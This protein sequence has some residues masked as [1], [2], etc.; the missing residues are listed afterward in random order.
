MYD[1]NALNQYAAIA[2][3]GAAAFVPQFDAD[4]NQTLI[5]T[6]TGIWSAIYNAENR[7]TSFTNEESGTVVECTYDSMGRR[8]YKKVTT[9]GSVTLHQRYIYRGYLQIACIDLTRS[10]H[11]CMWLLTWDPSQPDASRPLAIQINGTWYTYGWDLTK[12]ICEIYGSSGYIATTYTYTPFGS[13][14]DSGAVNQPIQWSSEYHD[15]ESSLVYYNYRYYNS[16]DGRWITRDFIS[17]K[18]RYSKNNTILFADLLGLEDFYIT[19]TYSYNLKFTYR[20][21]QANR[22]YLYSGFEINDKYKVTEKV[23]IDCSR[24]TSKRPVVGIKNPNYKVVKEGN[25]I[26]ETTMQMHGFGAYG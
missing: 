21:T 9:N 26:L 18:N 15:E 19:V 1:T 22:L 6:E 8:A 23:N 11:P 2:E 25:H 4:G 14:I 20:E 12:N 24:R 5:K 10:H 13:V 17:K 7:P 16:M 3:N